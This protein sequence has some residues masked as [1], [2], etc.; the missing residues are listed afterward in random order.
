MSTGLL[1]ALIGQGVVIVLS[2]IVSIIRILLH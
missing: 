2:I 1:V